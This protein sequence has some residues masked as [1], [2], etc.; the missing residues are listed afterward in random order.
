MHVI[1]EWKQR[2]LE[3]PMDMLK[4]PLIMSLAQVG[5]LLHCSVGYWRMFNEVSG[6]HW[7]RYNNNFILVQREREKSM[8]RCY[9]VL[10]ISFY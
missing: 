6:R 3:M 5:Y 7:M 2:S 4:R 1:W 9:R 10:R 8:V